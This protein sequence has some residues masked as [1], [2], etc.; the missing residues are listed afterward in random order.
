MTIVTLEVSVRQRLIDMYVGAR[1]S[2]FLYKTFDRAGVDSRKV[3][4]S[5][6]AS[7]VVDCSG[8]LFFSGGPSS[9]ALPLAGV[10]VLLQTADVHFVELD[11]PV[12]RLV[13]LI[14]RLPNPV[15]EIPRCLVSY[16]QIAMRSH[17]GSTLDA[18]RQMYIANSHVREGRFEDCINVP[19]RT[20]KNLRQALQ[21]GI[22]GCFVFVSTFSLSHRGHR[23]PS[24]QRVCT[25]QSSAACSSGN[26]SKHSGTEIMSLVGLSRAF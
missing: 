24:G 13:I 25:N 20:E 17:A 22:V 8:N 26:I 3:F 7:G 19:V 11:R 4:N 10:F 6:L 2:G 12:K 21:N 9:R 23:I 15:S 14:P 16:L 18:G 5:D 1:L